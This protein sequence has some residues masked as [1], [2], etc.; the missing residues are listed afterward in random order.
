M[1]ELA[2]ISPGTANVSS[3]LARALAGSTGIRDLSGLGK[4]E[5]RRTAAAALDVDAEVI[6]ITPTRALVVCPPERTAALLTSLPGIVVDVSGALAGIAVEGDDL[7]RRLS[8]L[9]LA[10]L[11][12]AGKVAGVQAVVTRSGSGYAFYFAQEYGDSVV[13]AVRDMQEGL[14]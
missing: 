9:D 11:P 2:F 3:P 10:T 8:D 6:P 4:L 14:A 5:V 1:S 7:M 12:S 13:E